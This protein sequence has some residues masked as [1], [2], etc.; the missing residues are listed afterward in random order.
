MDTS[1]TLAAIEAAVEDNA[2]RGHR[3]HLGASA[4][5]R[6]C[7]R[8]LWYIFRWAKE[9]SFIGRMLRLFARGDREEFALE[10]LLKIIGC[11]VWTA[12][13]N[14]NQFRCSDCNGHFGGSLDGVAKGI[15]TIPDGEACLTEFKTHNDKSFK[16]LKEAGLVGSKFEHYAQM[17]V[18]MYKYNLKYGLYMA[19]NKNDD[20]LFLEIVL[21]NPDVAI[22]HIKRADDI[23]HSQ[24]PPRKINESAAW[25]QCRFC[26]FKGICHGN[27]KAEVNCRTCKFSKPIENGQW[28]CDKYNV[29]IASDL[30][31]SGC[32]SHDPL[33]C[34]KK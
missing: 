17:Q 28:H 33:D 19:V 34:F 12:D 31:V 14:G 23:I 25:W 22:Q 4:I 21:L 2:E 9:E 27:D 20:H 32:E 10:E 15:P 24:I 26:N 7:S 16:K 30:M 13:E 18:Y 11:Q 1:K 8:E 5:G 6:P 3:N 29:G